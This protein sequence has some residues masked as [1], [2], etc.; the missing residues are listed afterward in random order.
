MISLINTNILINFQPLCNDSE[1]VFCQNCHSTLEAFQL[2]KSLCMHTQEIFSSR[3]MCD[4][5]IH[6][7]EFIVG[8]EVDESVNAVE[9]ATMKQETRCYTCDICQKQCKTKRDLRIHFGNFHVGG[10]T[11]Q[12]KDETDYKC[13]ECNTKLSSLRNLKR[14][15]DTHN[16]EKCFKCTYCN[17]KFNSKRNQYYHEKYV[18]KT[19]RQYICSDCGYVCYNPTLMNVSIVIFSFPSENLTLNCTFSNIFN[20]IIA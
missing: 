13:K 10:T 20:D 7:E 8:F 9:I 18:H 19:G 14:H 11:R 2:F 5:T 12:G 6:I 4:E 16:S 17:S 1:V 3:Q 15:Q